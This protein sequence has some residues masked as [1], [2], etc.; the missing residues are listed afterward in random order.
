MEVDSDKTGLKVPSGQNAAIVVKSD[1]RSSLIF[2]VSA[3]AA[4][5]L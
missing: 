1:E 5:A 2:M 4:A 3:T